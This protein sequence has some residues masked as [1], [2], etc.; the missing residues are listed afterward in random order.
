VA[1][2][3]DIASEVVLKII[4]SLSNRVIC[5]PR[6]TKQI[7]FLLLLLH[8]LQA[9]T[10]LLLLV[11]D[12]SVAGRYLTFTL[13]STADGRLLMGGLKWSLKKGEEL[14]RVHEVQALPIL[15]THPGLYCLT[16]LREC[17]A[18]ARRLAL[19]RALFVLNTAL[20]ISILN[21]VRKVASL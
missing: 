10:A 11:A 5:P 12:S 1:A 13:Y 14:L 17:T 2:T 16:D 18:P 7:C 15:L 3:I 19:R 9:L 21:A 20:P 6:L 8:L 4:V